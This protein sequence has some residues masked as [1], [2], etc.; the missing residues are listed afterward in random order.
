M[1]SEV[2]PGDATEVARLRALLTD[3]AASVPLDWR[4]TATEETIFRVMLAHD[5]ATP[6]LIAEASGTKSPESGRVHIFRIRN[7]LKPRAVEIE[8]LH[9]RGW[10]LI[11]REHWARQLAP[12]TALVAN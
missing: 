4:L 1:F 11:G 10:R 2:V 6:A 3:S 12:A 7:K 5:C 8:T 9:G